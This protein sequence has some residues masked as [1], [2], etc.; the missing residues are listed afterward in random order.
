MQLTSNCKIQM[1]HAKKFR[2]IE[3]DQRSNVWALATFIVRMS[4][5]PIVGGFGQ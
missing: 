5:P 2:E 1:T 3:S 4:V